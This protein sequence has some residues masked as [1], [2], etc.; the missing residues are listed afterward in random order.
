MAAITTGNVFACH[1]MC[2]LLQEWCTGRK[3]SWTEMYAQ[4]CHLW[5][6][7]VL[8][9]DPKHSR[10]CNQLIGMLLCSFTSGYPTASNGQTFPLPVHI[11]TQPTT[12]AFKDQQSGAVWTSLPSQTPVA[13]SGRVSLHDLHRKEGHMQLVMAIA[14]SNTCAN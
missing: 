1:T 5:I 14:K 4:A 11:S 12:A 8:Q 13:Y 3:M 6:A 2:L 9:I 7:I 10:D